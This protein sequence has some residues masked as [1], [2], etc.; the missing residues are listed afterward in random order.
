M[1]KSLGELKDDELVN[2][3]GSWLGLVVPSFVGGILAFVLYNL[4]ISTIVSGQ[5]FPE[6]A[7]DSGV[8]PAESF[9]MLMAQHLK[10]PQDYAKLF[11]CRRRA[12]RTALSVSQ[13]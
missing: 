13:S 5:L 7:T 11:F 4:F 3:A 12:L 2:L 8:K 10:A 1:H 6:F 9:D